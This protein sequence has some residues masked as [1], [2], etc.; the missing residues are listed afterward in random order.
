MN[1]RRVE[2]QLMKWAVF[3]ME[4][5]KNKEW[6]LYRALDHAR[7]ADVYVDYEGDLVFNIHVNPD[8]EAEFYDELEAALIAQAKKW[9]HGG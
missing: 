8:A 7:V 4:T 3:G 6:I 1:L 5:K 9:E 2:L